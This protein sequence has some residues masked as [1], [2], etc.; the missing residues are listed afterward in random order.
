LSDIFHEIDEELRRDNL[1]KLLSRYWPYLAGVVVLA[2]AIAG[3]IA[4]WRQHQLSAR[5]AQSTQYAAA[6]AL[7]GHGKDAE[8]ARLFGALAQESG[9]YPD[10]AAFEQ[11][12]LAAKSN[13]SKQAI[14][15]YDHIAATNAHPTFRDLAVVLAAMQ[16]MRAEA[17]PGSVITK[18]KPLTVPGSPWRP[19][20]LELS[21]LAKLK[22]GDKS[23]AR[24][25]YQG[26]AADPSA[27]P[28]LR[29]RASEMVAALSS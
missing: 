14:A 7:A 19:T 27:P 25:I 16:H 15:L 17:D 23:G 8:A 28:G 5:Q 26:L 18:L 29:A 20:A 6:L 13:H 10:L 2:L 3:G 12:A 1:L 11:A 9:G 22:K 24:Q 21:A 4:G